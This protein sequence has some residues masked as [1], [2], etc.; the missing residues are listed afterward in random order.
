MDYIQKI[1]DTCQTTW[2]DL[3]IGFYSSLPDFLAPERAEIEIDKTI[4]IQT[5]VFYYV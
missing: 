2:H 4:N 1:I 3:R 5:I